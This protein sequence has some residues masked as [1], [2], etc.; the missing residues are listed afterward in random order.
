MATSLPPVA[1]PE[2]YHWVFQWYI[3][4]LIVYADIIQ[5]RLWHY[6]FST[7]GFKCSIGIVV[8]QFGSRIRRNGGEVQ[9][10]VGTGK[11]QMAF[12]DIA[13]FHT[14]CQRIVSI[15]CI[16]ILMRAGHIHLLYLTVSPGLK[17]VTMP[18]RSAGNF[19]TS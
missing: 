15:G 1:V 11:I 5:A 14:L 3:F 8:A 10:C 12:I 16:K 4:C 2:T 7:I 17:S 18:V 6:N 19:S 9:L 13:V